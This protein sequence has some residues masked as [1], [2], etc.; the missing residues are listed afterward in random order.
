MNF[1]IRLFYFFFQLNQ[2]NASISNKFY[3]KFIPGFVDVAAGAKAGLLKW[4]EIYFISL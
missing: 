3:K 1:K 2:V 4:K